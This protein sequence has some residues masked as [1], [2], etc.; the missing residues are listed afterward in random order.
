VAG[1]GSATWATA[2][3]PAYVQTVMADQPLAYYRL[4]ELSGTVAHDVSGHGY[5]GTYVVS[6]G[7]LTLG[8]SGALTDDPAVG[9]IGD[10]NTGSGGQAFVTFPAQLNV[11][12]ADFTIEGWVTPVASPGG[13]DAAF[14]VW[15]VYNT[16]GFRTGWKGDMTPHLWTAESGGS[17]GGVESPTP[18]IAGAWNYFVI[19]RAGSTIS[20]YVGGQLAMTGAPTLVTPPNDANNSYGASE[21]LPAGNVFD[22]LAIY[23][24]A[25]DAS[26]IAAHYAAAE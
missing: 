17:T 18:L 24:R 19:T 10:G 5:D 26:R 20:V 12:A 21:G 16:S 7:T 23:D 22:E 13:Y 9:L 8:L 14:F 6:G 11:F 2:R 3:R 25:L 15:E 4:D 1:S